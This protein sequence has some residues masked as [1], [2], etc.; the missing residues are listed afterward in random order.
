GTPQLPP[1]SHGRDPGGLLMALTRIPPIGKYV[2]PAGP[3]PILK[4]LLSSAG[5]AV[6]LFRTTAKAAIRSVGRRALY[7]WRDGV[8]GWREA[9]IGRYMRKTYSRTRPIRARPPFF[10]NI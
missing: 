4:N 10:L 1:R 5:A 7:G 6:P 9:G 8:P 2:P 3:V